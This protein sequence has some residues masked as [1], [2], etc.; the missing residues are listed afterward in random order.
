M[1]IP[2]IIRI[3][4]LEFIKINN[5]KNICYL[6]HDILEVIYSFIIKDYY[7]SKINKFIIN[8]IKLHRSIKEIIQNVIIYDIYSHNTQ[9]VTVYNIYSHNRYTHN[10]IESSNIKALES[11]VD[12]DIPRK[13]DLNFWANYLQVLSSQINKLRFQY[14]CNNIGYKTPNGKKLTII[15]E[16][17]LQLCKKFN[18]KIYLRRNKSEKYIRAKNISKMNNYDQYILA[19]I[20]IK[21]FTDNNWVNVYDSKDYLNNIYDECFSNTF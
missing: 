6:S 1:K 3:P 16:L 9:Q 2:D 10:I 7:G 14:R 4:M 13:Y 21:P 15:L 12:S 5:N 8:K 18:F 17:W 19:P 20:I 11:I